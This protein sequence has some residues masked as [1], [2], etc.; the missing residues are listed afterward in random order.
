MN[1]RRILVIALSVSVF[2]NLLLF[3]YIAGLETKTL[4]PEQSMDPSYGFPRLLRALPADRK[5]ELMSSISEHRRDLGGEY[6]EVGRAQASMFR[7]FLAEPFDIERLRDSSA[8]YGDSLCKARA[9]TDTVFLHIV[10]QL[11]HEERKVLLDSAKHEWR[12][13]NRDSQERKRATNKTDQDS[14]DE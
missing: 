12:R 10:E 8:L 14:N 2:T 7:D 6:R 11:T 1:K 9:R 13:V 3:G 4:A 5:S